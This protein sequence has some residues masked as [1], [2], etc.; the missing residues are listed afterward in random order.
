MEA[1]I[2]RPAASRARQVFERRVHVVEQVS[3]EVVGDYRGRRRRGRAR[4]R[5]LGLRLQVGLR[6]LF[7][8]HDRSA[9]LLDGKSRD[10]LRLAVVQKPKVFFGEVAHGMAVAV[11]HDCGHGHQVHPRRKCRGSFLRLH[12]GLLR[13]GERAGQEEESKQAVQ[14]HDSAHSFYSRPR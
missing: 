1:A 7:L 14:F 9:G 5:R 3:H 13:R 6:G 11:A 12:F 2:T 8:Q 10:G 4:F